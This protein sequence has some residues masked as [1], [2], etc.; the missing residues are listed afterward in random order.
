MQPES[1]QRLQKR[2]CACA[3]DAVVTGDVLVLYDSMALCLWSFLF[4]CSEVFCMRLQ[5]MAVL[6]CTTA[7]G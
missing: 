7:R 1:N 2:I 5:R 4:V 6:L 3:L